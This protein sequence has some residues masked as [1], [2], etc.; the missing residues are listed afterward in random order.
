MQTLVK[1]TL[2]SG[3]Y[4]GILSEDSFHIHEK[5]KEFLRNK[6]RGVRPLVDL[7]I[8]CIA[9]AAAWWLG[10]EYKALW[11]QIITC[12]IVTSSLV[13]FVSLIHEAFHDN[14]ASKK[15]NDFLATWLLAP[16]LLTDYEMEKNIHLSHHKYLGTEYD[17]TYP[18]YKMSLKELY[19]NL[20]SRI[21]V[22]GTIMLF[23]RKKMDLK[24]KPHERST[25]I[26]FK[27]YF[28]LVLIQTF[29]FSVFYFNYPVSYLWNW[30]FPL[31]LSSVLSSVREFCEHKSFDD[32]H[33]ACMVNTHACYFE[34]LFVSGSNFNLHAVHHIFPRVPYR[35]LSEL[36]RLLIKYGWPKINLPI[37]V[38]NTYMKTLFNFKGKR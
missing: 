29:I 9:I 13:S 20:I 32:T 37:F 10:F 11:I 5:I 18:A 1:P 6:K 24:F 27:R 14:L 34:R 7:I 36:S 38:T 22:I 4:V 35:Q 19:L 15:I 25:K 28:A 2:A 8:C 31:I 16:A 21:F 17:P 3:E 23:I 30:F 26:E 33:K 12:L